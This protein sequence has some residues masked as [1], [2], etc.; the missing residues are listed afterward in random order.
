MKILILQKYYDYQQ[1]FYVQ[2]QRLISSVSTS[3][4]VKRGGSARHPEGCVPALVQR[5]QVSPPE[6]GRLRAGGEDRLLLE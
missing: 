5:L 6:C 1:F 3:N 4:L 2:K